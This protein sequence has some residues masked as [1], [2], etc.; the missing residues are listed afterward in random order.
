MATDPTEIINALEAQ[1]KAWFE[2]EENWSG[3]SE[4]LIEVEG[5]LPED[6]PTGGFLNI[7]DTDPGQPDDVL[8]G[9]NEAY[10]SH[11]FE[12]DIIAASG[13][14]A[15]RRTRYA[16]LVA[17]LGAAIAADKTLGG[18]VA[19]ILYGQPAAAAERILG[20]DDWKAATLSLSI[21]Y[22]ATDRIPHD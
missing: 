12:I 13:I 5:I 7:W 6:I 11:I 2:D 10:Y 15:T 19:G 17:G 9:F 22:H 4:V 14:A 1:I 8:G 20:G 16:A 21:D 18:L 3:D